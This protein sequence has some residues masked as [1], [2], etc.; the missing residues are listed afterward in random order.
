MST[1][2]ENSDAIEI[3]EATGNVRLRGYS[4]SSI[5]TYVAI[6]GVDGV[7]DMGHCHA[8]FIGRSNV[9]LT[10]TH[11]DHVG[12]LPHFIARRALRGMGR[13]TVYVP[14]A[15]ERSL[16]NF[17]VGAAGCDGSTL[18]DMNCGVVGVKPG[19]RIDISGR[20]TIEVIPAHHVLP[21]VGYLVIEN[22]RKKELT[23]DPAGFDR[24][25]TDMHPLVAFIGDSTIDAI[26]SVTAQADVLVIE[27]TFVDESEKVLAAKHGHTHIDDLVDLMV[28]KPE[29]VEKN[30]KIVLKHQSLR[31]KRNDYRT[32]I[33]AKIP[34][35][36]SPR[37]LFLT[38]A[39]TT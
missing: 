21:S 4:I 1:S 26:S 6:D 20:K 12:G 19:D 15:S 22:R 14:E 33:L 34:E 8:G 38:S 11:M 27:C 3:I 9:F 17:L 18:E 23:P 2:L 10:H 5:A 13:T 25:Y 30:K 35:E 36:F 7:F 37:I 29:L 32:K 28:R 24:Y 31:H 16:M 39:N